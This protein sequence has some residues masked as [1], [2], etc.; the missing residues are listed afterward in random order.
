[1]KHKTKDDLFIRIYGIFTFTKDSSLCIQE[2]GNP[3]ITP[4]CK[5]QHVGHDL[6][7]LIESYSHI[8]SL[9]GGVLENME[10]FRRMEE[11]AG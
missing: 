2:G 5:S 3:S 10:Q 4:T 9:T 8:R 7:I 11:I 1:M 6:P